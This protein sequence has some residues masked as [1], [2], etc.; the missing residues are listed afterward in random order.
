MFI[1]HINS[2]NFKIK[3]L[4]SKFSAVPKKDFTTVCHVT[5]IE[6]WFY[7]WAF[8]RY[9]RCKLS[10]YQGTT[11][12][13][14]QRKIDFA[15]TKY[16]SVVVTLS[17]VSFLKTLLSFPILYKLDHL[18]YGFKFGPVS[19]KCIALFYSYLSAV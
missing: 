9:R 17:L 3:N 14:P 10:I 1:F 16:A 12:R 11:K 13:V 4:N 18:R 6:R 2:E 7:F 19:F 8:P 5:I 15:N